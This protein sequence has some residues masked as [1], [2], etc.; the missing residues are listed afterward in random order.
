MKDPIEQLTALIFFQ[1]CLEYIIYMYK[2]NKA[3]LRSFRQVVGRRESIMNAS[4]VS[5]PEVFRRRQRQFG[6]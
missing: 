5:L 6:R 1:I 2:G 4:R 3:R